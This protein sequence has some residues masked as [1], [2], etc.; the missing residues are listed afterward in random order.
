L[1]APAKDELRQ[2]LEDLDI[3]VLTPLEGLNVLDQL[4]KMV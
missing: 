4:K 2:K 3:S 1:F